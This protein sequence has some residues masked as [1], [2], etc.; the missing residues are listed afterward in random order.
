M[1]SINIYLFGG[2]PRRHLEFRHIEYRL[3]EIK[4]VYNITIEKRNVNLAGTYMHLAYFYIPPH[5]ISLDE[6]ER[7]I[8]NLS[9]FQIRS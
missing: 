4:H 3:W 9:L 5:L 2:P 8:R 6:Y 1:V 7:S